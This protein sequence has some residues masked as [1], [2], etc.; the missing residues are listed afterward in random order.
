MTVF[1]YLEVLSI[2]LLSATVFEHFIQ[3]ETLDT[4][5]IQYNV[6]FEQVLDRMQRSQKVVSICWIDRKTEE[7]LEIVKK[8]CFCFNE[9]PHE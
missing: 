9:A 1:Y 7:L 4:I 8:W 6:Y 2:S 5:L 3:V